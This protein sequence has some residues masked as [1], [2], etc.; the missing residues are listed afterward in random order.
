M[1]KDIFLS[2]LG[3]QNR[4]DLCYDFPVIS[5]K[6]CGIDI[7]PKGAEKVEKAFMELSWELYWFDCNLLVMSPYSSL[8]KGAG[9]TF[10]YILHKLI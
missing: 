3:Y 2:V 10:K 4:Q 6:C 5:I 1:L 9:L 8:L 7:Y